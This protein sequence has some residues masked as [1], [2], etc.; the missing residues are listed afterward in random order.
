MIGPLKRL[1]SK[2]NSLN[3]VLGDVVLETVPV[4]GRHSDKTFMLWRVKRGLDGHFFLGVKLRPD[5]FAGPEGAANNF[6]NF[7]LKS[8]EKLRTD[9]DHCIAELKRLDAQG[10]KD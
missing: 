5:A 1:L 9:L 8:A 10:Q 3:A 2:S 7:D 6:I 4:S